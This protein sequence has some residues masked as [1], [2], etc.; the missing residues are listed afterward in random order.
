MSQQ[1]EQDLSSGITRPPGLPPRGPLV[2]T[3]GLAPIPEEE[4]GTLDPEDDPRLTVTVIDPPT[5]DEEAALKEAYGNRPLYKAVIAKRNHFVYT[6]LTKNMEESIRDAQFRAAPR[7]D[8]QRL[9]AMYRERVLQGCTVWPRDFTIT[10]LQ[11]MPAGVEYSLFNKIMGASGM[12]DP[13]TLD[14]TLTTMIDTPGPTEDD[15]TQLKT[16]PRLQRLGLVH[17]TIMATETDERGIPVAKPVFHVV[18]TAIERLV[19]SKIQAAS[20]M[21]T[22]LNDEYLKVGVVWPKDVNWDAMPAGWAQ[23]VANGILELSGFTMGAAEDE[24]L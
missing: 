3:E 4:Y 11:Q 24:E 13:E 6:I 18:Y 15:I 12:T 16:D 22:D 9:D 19:F 5:E 17:R 8:P 2:H 14:V 20:S 1:E 7:L 23:L 10:K 21:E